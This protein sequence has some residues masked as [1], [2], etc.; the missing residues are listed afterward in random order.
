VDFLKSYV[1]RTLPCV[2]NELMEARTSTT[3][4]VVAVK[5]DG[6]PYLLFPEDYYTE[7]EES[8]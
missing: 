6:H 3:P 7:K 2:T 1:A 8:S 5:Y 4:A